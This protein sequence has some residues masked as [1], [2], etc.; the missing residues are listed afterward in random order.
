MGGLTSGIFSKMFSDKD[1]KGFQT[2]INRVLF[3]NPSKVKDAE[4]CYEQKS[5]ETILQSYLGKRLYKEDI[6]I[7][8]NIF[9]QNIFAPKRKIDIRKRGKKCINSILSEDNLFYRIDSRTETGNGHRN[10]TV[11]KVVPWDEKEGGEDD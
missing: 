7:F 8:K 1:K 9:F 4:L 3:Q 11:W 2:Y 5:I 6:E 10:E